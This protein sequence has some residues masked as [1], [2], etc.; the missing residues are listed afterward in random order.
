[1]LVVMSIVT[2]KKFNFFDEGFCGR[3]NYLVEGDAAR[4]FGA[5]SAN[6]LVLLIFSSFIGRVFF[7]FIKFQIPKNS[8]ILSFYIHFF[9]KKL[10]CIK[11]NHSEISAAKKNA[12][13]SV[14]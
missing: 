7:I 6:A 4:N 11:R 8:K 14:G 13:P 12:P 10:I 5:P 3:E 1:M 9:K 2:M